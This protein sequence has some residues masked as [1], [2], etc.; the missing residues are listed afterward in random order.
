MQ[1]TGQTLPCQAPSRPSYIPGHPSLNRRCNTRRVRRSLDPPAPGDRRPVPDPPGPGTPARLGQAAQ[2]PRVPLHPIRDL[3]ARRAAPF[4][5]VFMAELAIAWQQQGVIDRHCDLTRWHR[6][7]LPW[8][9]AKRTGECE[10]VR[11]G[12]ETL[13]LQLLTGHELAADPETAPHSPCSRARE[14]AARIHQA[15]GPLT[16]LYAKFRKSLK[17]G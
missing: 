10:R 12:M 13:G 5:S 17:T 11:R 14:L 2:G 9:E 4:R 15:A 1:R 8:Q 6:R 7:L 16:R 3:P